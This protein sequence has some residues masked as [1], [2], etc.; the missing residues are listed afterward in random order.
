MTFDEYLKK[1]VMRWVNNFNDIPYTVI[2]KLV[3]HD[4]IDSVIELTDNTNCDSYFPM[5]RFWAFDNTWDEDY[6]RENID[7]MQ[8]CGLRVYEQEDYG[9]IFGIDGYGYSFYEPHWLPLYKSFFPD[10]VKW[11]KDEYE[12]EINT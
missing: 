9:L 10:I 8:K 7:I 6:A 12:K 3:E 4:G 11:R 1:Y 2:D 5:V